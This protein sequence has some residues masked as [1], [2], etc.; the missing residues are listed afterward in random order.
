MRS[1]LVKQ[2]ND[3]IISKL[4]DHIKKPNISYGPW[5]AGGAARMLWFDKPWHEHDIDFFFPTVKMFDKIK[6]KLDKLVL[7]KSERKKNKTNVEKLLSKI[8]GQDIFEATTTES[9]K[10]HVTPNACTYT[11]T[12]DKTEIKAQI[13][14]RQF[15]QT[16]DDVWNDFDF[17]VC[18][19]A[20]D[21]KILIADANGIEDCK[22]Q[23]LI[24]NEPLTRR[25]DVKRTIKYSLY[26]FSPEEKI[27]RELFK[28]HKDGTLMEGWKDDY[29]S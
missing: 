26:G 10:R 15:Y 28:Q 8:R 7:T 13:I 11:L 12:F 24:C 25:I 17:R 20:T 29:P 6:K 3:P 19:F 5:I 1:I 18:N 14:N 16:V 2:I 4:L 21:G 27:V 9:S 23:V 22:N